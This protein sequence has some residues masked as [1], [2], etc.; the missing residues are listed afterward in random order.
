[1]TQ[2]VRATFWIVIEDSSGV[3]QGYIRSASDWRQVRRL[4]RAGSFSFSMPAGDSAAGLVV[5][6]RIARCYTVHDGA[7][8][9]V[10]AGIIDRITFNDSGAE[11]MLQVDG[12]DML[13]ELTYRTVGR[14]TIGGY[15]EATKGGL[16]QIKNKAFPAGWAYDTTSEHS[17]NTT[18]RAIYQPLNNETAL[19][20][21]SKLADLTGENFILGAGRT[22][23]WLRRQTLTAP[24]Q[25]MQHRAAWSFDAENALI[26][27]I[28]Y[29]TD[30]YEQCSRVYAVGGNFS[31]TNYDPDGNPWITI[32]GQLTMED[33][34]REYIAGAFLLPAGYTLERDQDESLTWRYYVNH[35]ATQAS[36]GRID[37][38]ESW[39]EIKPIDGFSAAEI[40]VCSKHL[41]LT[42]VEY[43]RQR[44]EGQTTVDV[45]LA[46]GNAILLPGTALR[47]FY[48][49]VTDGYTE[50]DLW[51]VDLLV[52]EST[53][54]IDAAGLRTASI[55]AT[56][57]G[58]WPRTDG[59]VMGDMQNT[60]RYLAALTVGLP[61]GAMQQAL[62]QG[63]AS[64]LGQ[65]VASQLL[66]V[67]GVDGVPILRWEGNTETGA[68]SGTIGHPTQP[69]IEWSRV[70]GLL[71]AGVPV[72]NLVAQAGM[73][74]GAV[75]VEATPYTM[76]V[77]DCIVIATASNDLTLPATAAAAGRHY[78]VK[79]LDGLTLMADADIVDFGSS[80]YAMSANEALT[81]VSDGTYWYVIGGA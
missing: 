54:Q 19:A 80:H 65:G 49:A 58:R 51:G 30:T 46:G 14:L 59:E 48:R 35:A 24:F 67:R 22:V 20:A 16:T 11:R 72:A 61:N 78:T 13:R 68:E 3:P 9:E 12:G 66:E 10:G 75:R 4:N 44:I 47:V 5:R 53:T 23:R 41:V 21:L 38:F 71:I 25:I 55:Q 77:N 1:M 32:S 76:A 34:Y 40:M 15:R 26:T 69:H 39:S 57:Y 52:L 37:R 50:L 18:E 63:V 6:K 79:S 17:Y 62:G 74:A 81:L 36:I 45:G 28:S 64:A 73:G 33:A 31:S 7:V 43:L 27:S 56:T 2:A 70:D 60:L 8:I 42:A 29:D